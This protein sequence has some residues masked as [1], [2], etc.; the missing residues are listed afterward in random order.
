MKPAAAQP[1]PGGFVKAAGVVGIQQRPVVLLHDIDQRL[2][3]AVLGGQRDDGVSLNREGR[4]RLHCLHHHPS[5][6]EEGI[7]QSFP[8]QGRRFG[9]AAYRQRKFLLQQGKIRAAV[10][11]LLRIQMIAVGV[12]DQAGVYPSQV[13]PAIQC[14]QIGVRPPVQQQ[15]IV[16]E[17]LTAGAEVAASQPSRLLTGVAGAEGAGDPL[18]RRRAQIGQLHA[19]HLR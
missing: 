18:G 11:K 7:P 3:R 5:G 2:C 1:F 4:E 10:F 16:D 17:R 14:M 8:Q 19:G 12:R 13:Q 9:G 6:I 15:P